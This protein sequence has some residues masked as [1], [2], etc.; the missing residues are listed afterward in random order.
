[1][2]RFIYLLFIFFAL[3]ACEEE[4]LTP[5]TD[6]MPNTDGTVTNPGGGT[7][8]GSLGS[9]NMS[10][11][12]D[13]QS[14]S[15]NSIVATE[16]MGMI[17]IVGTNTS[18][19]TQVGITLNTSTKVGTYNFDSFLYTGTYTKNVA[20]APLIYNAN[21]PVLEITSIDTTNRKIEGLFVFDAVNRDDPNDQ[22]KVTNGEFKITYV[23][24]S[25]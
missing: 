23:P 15:S 18:N 25:F 4:P 20:P 24:F 14:W 11:T 9:G 17:S 7:G 19:S 16:L 3:T 21:G 8:G 12:V 1:M 5:Y 10:A 13:G 6:A 2:K 22:I